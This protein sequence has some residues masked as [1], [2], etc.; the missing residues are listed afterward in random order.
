MLGKVGY[1]IVLLFYCNTAVQSIPT[2]YLFLVQTIYLFPVQTIYLF[3]VQTIYL[4]P[5]SDILP[6]SCS[7]NLPI[8]CFRQFTYFLFRQFTYFLFPFP[9]LFFSLLFLLS[10]Q[11]CILHACSVA[12]YDGFKEPFT[13]CIQISVHRKRKHF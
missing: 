13:C 9:L 4:F 2:I 10:S 1:I 3:P 11:F 5:V 7:N 12:L 8:S 6:I